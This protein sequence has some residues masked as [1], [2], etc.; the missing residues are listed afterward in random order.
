MVSLINIR[1][2][3]PI[4]VFPGT[5]TL[6]LVLVLLLG[7]TGA[8]WFFGGNII[9]SSGRARIEFFNK[10]SVELDKTTDKM[11]F[12]KTSSQTALYNE[13]GEIIGA[14]EKEKRVFYTGKRIDESGETLVSVMLRNQAGNFVEGNEAYIPLSRIEPVYEEAGYSSILG[15]DKQSPKTNSQS[16]N[17]TKK[18]KEGSILLSMED[19]IKPWDDSKLIFPLD[20]LSPG[21]K[22]KLISD[23]NVRIKER[24]E[25]NRTPGVLVALGNY[26]MT[27]FMKGSR[28]KFPQGTEFKF[29]KG[30]K[31]LA[32]LGVGEILLEESFEVEIIK[33]GGS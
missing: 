16:S 33:K 28:V 29:Y 5:K 13:K 22:I 11:K 7:I 6:G 24:R 19:D 15:G 32:L 31:V 10:K 12:Y 3:N 1:G 20:D 14:V 8:Y 30:K 17:I 9:D 23:V 27:D 26:E 25:K 4:K 18:S 2:Y 21:D